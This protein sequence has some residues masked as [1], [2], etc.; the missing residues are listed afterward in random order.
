MKTV[1]EYIAS[2]PV[3]IQKMLTRIRNIILKYA[4][5]AEESLVYKMPAYKTFGKTLIYFAG[6]KD[7]IGLYATPSGHLEFTKELAKYKHGKGSVQFPVNEPIPYELI[8]EIV[9][10]RVW[11]NKNN[12][13]TKTKKK[14]KK[15]KF[16]FSVASRYR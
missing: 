3:D 6:F 7:H 2:F 4:P 12:F 5:D 14:K 15:N 10:F 11:E 1:D 8:R 13:E 9:E 16:L